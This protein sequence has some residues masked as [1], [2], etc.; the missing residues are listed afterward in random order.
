MP[1][2]GLN[3]TGRPTDPTL[4]TLKRPYPAATLATLLEMVCHF[5]DSTGRFGPSGP[6]HATTNPISLSQPSCF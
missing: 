3:M 5:I 2:V 6:P 4:S 1:F